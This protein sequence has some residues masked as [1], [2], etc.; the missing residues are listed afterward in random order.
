MGKKNSGREEKNIPAESREWIFAR[1]GGGFRSVRVSTGKRQSRT[2]F[3]GAARPG[4]GVEGPSLIRDLIDTVASTTVAHE[5][6]L[7]RRPR[8]DTHTHTPWNGPRPIVAGQKD[9]GRNT[10]VTRQND[11]TRG[12]EGEKRG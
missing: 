11:G 4:A 1:V 3:K 7:A 6:A 2:R 10:Y 5:R 8:T 12:W 9:G